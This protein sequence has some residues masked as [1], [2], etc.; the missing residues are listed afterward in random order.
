[1]FSQY[2]RLTTYND[3]VSLI[4]ETLNELKNKEVRVGKEIIPVD[5]EQK[6]Q[7]TKKAKELTQKLFKD[8]KNSIKT[9]LSP[10]QMTIQYLTHTVESLMA[11]VQAQKEFINSTKTN[12]NEQILYQNYMMIE[13]LKHEIERMYSKQYRLKQMLQQKE[14]E[15]QMIQ[16]NDT[17]NLISENRKLKAENQQLKMYLRKVINVKPKRSTH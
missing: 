7:E 5:D 11:Q 13:S 10:E 12:V 16:S 6:F 9:D 2:K 1:M 17:S 14:K 8:I 3:E 4:P 15:I